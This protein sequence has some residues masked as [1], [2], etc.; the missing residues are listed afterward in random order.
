[1][2]AVKTLPT[3]RRSDVVCPEPRN[4]GELVFP[5]KAMTEQWYGVIHTIVGFENNSKNGGGGRFNFITSNGERT[6]Q[7]EDSYK[8]EFTHM[9]P[10]D[11]RNKIRSV[12][13]HH[14]IGIEGFKFYDKEGVLLWQI[15][16]TNYQNCKVDT[17]L[18]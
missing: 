12:A 11:S 2:K 6:T 16:N 5:T 3:I 4:I 13:I 8:T 7:T 15:G 17:V 9:M 18:I 1:M 14:F 10:P